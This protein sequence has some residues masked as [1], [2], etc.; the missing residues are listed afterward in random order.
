MT[1]YGAVQAADTVSALKPNLLASKAMHTGITEFCLIKNFG[2]KDLIDKE[3]RKGTKNVTDGGIVNYYDEFKTSMNAGIKGKGDKVTVRYRP[4]MEEEPTEGDNFDSEANAKSWTYDTFDFS[5][6]LGTLGQLSP[7]LMEK[8]RT[9]ANVDDDI[10]LSLKENTQDWL[11]KECM[12]KLAGVTTYDF[13]NTPTVPSSY[14]HQFAGTATSSGTMNESD[15][16][17]I[18]DLDKL[19]AVAYYKGTGL[20]TVQPLRRS[21]G[22]DFLYICHPW[23]AD[24]MFQSAKSILKDS[25][26]RGEHNKLFTGDFQYQFTYRKI[27]VV[28]SSHLPVY[29]NYGALGNV[30]AGRSVFLGRNAL[31]FGSALDAELVTETK[32]AATRIIK[33]MKFICGMQKIK[34]ATLDVDLGVIAHDSAA[35]SLI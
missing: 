3:N 20:P 23:V 18:R 6:M 13:G 11:A 34:P 15:V 16:A 30:E 17:T 4:L 27:A 5:I 12:R 32:N 22:I 26:V 7:G 19:L 29:T 35:E 9:A 33:T 10:T 25:D 1:S 28:V 14:R 2:F 31:A 8:Q 21:D 24:N